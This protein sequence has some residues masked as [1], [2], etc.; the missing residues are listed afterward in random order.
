M[1][2]EVSKKLI[3]LFTKKGDLIL[4]PFC[5][6]GNILLNAKRTGRKTFGIDIN[7]K[8]VNY[9]M[10]RNINVINENALNIKKISLPK[11]DACIT[12]PPFF[13]LSTNDLHL[14]EDLSEI[15]NYSN[16]LKK[17]SSI[18]INLKKYLKKDKYLVVIIKNLY[19]NEKF[20][21]LAWD[22]VSKLKKEYVLCRELIW[23]K[24][25]KYYK[26]INYRN[27]TNHTYILVFRNSINK[28]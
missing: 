25:K 28:K 14:K 17:L 8:T 23:V 20:I 19:I 10:K 6:Y 7:E 21:P 27:G 1:P 16:Y 4:D 18:F 12:S 15:K 13:H 2:N 24:S 9:C 26:K 3:K 11:A 22:L 5:G